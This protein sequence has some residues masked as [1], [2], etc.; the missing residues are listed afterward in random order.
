[1]SRIAQNPNSTKSYKTLSDTNLFQEYKLIGKLSKGTNVTVLDKPFKVNTKDGYS[2]NAYEL[3]MPN[4]IDT[5]IYGY[6]IGL[7][8]NPIQ[9]IT[10]SAPTPGANPPPLPETIFTPKNIVISLAIIGLIVGG[11]FGIKS[12]I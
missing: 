1:M 9:D 6:N 5:Y 7:G 11:Y 8:M 3:R 2:V 12:M 4:Y 10:M